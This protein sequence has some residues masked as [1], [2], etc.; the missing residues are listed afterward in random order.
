VSL[1]NSSI[2]TLNVRKKKRLSKNRSWQEK[3]SKE[4]K[5]VKDAKMKKSA[6]KG[7]KEKGKTVMK[8]GATYTSRYKSDLAPESLIVESPKKATYK[9]RYK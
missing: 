8:K 5:Q 2:G 7:L 3:V 4:L 9:S 1:T 6:S